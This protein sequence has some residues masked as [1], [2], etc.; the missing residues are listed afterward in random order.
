[1]TFSVFLPSILKRKK[2]AA[3]TTTTGMRDMMVI[4]KKLEGILEALSQREYHQHALTTRLSI[5][6]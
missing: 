6:V 1:V 5:R 4:V 3:T 2:Q